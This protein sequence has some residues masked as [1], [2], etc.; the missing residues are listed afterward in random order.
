MG[1]SVKRNL[2]V[3]QSTPRHN[4]LNAGIWMSAVR[5]AKWTLSEWP[6]KSKEKLSKIAALG[7]RLARN[8][9][10]IVQFLNRSLSPLKS[11]RPDD[12]KVLCKRQI[13]NRSRNSSAS[14]PDGLTR[15]E[16]HPL[17]CGVCIETHIASAFTKDSS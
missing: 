6:S 5:R 14:V 2:L 1:L 12:S 4:D 11:N 15:H 17:N 7:D 10:R 13:E 16:I 9:A 8:S 3:E